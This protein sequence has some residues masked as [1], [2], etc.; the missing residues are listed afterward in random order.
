MI[1]QFLQASIEFAKEIWFQLE[2]RFHLEDTEAF[3]LVEPY[4]IQIQDNPIYLLASLATLFLVPYT[5]LKVRSLSRDRERKLDELIEEMEEEYDEDDPRKLRRPEVDD[6]TDTPPTGNE[7]QAT[8]PYTKVID[9]VEEIKDTE[10]KLEVRKVELSKSANETHTTAF[11]QEE[12]DEDDPRRLRRPEVDDRTDSPKTGGT[13]SIVSQ[14]TE[15]E[16]DKNLDELTSLDENISPS[17]DDLINGQEDIRQPQDDI[18]STEL[19]EHLSDKDPLANNSELPELNEDEQ[20]KEIK[21]LQD[22][23]ERTI[24][25]LTQQAE[26]PTTSPASIKDLSKV[27]VEEDATDDNAFHEDSFFREDV[28]LPDTKSPDTKNDETLAQE[29]SAISDAEVL[30][31]EILAT[32]EPEFEEPVELDEELE[33]ETEE[34][35]EQLII[36]KT[37][38]YESELPDSTFDAEPEISSDELGFSN[39]SLISESKSMKFEETLDSELDKERSPLANDL[40]PLDASDK[41]IDRLKFLQTRFENRFQSTGQPMANAT[42]PIEKSIPVKDYARFTAPRSYSSAALPPDSEKYMEL[43]ESFVFMKDQKKHK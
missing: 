32:L 8:S 20:D 7:E 2:Y 30:A 43:L 11:K 6:K 26:E 39:E 15:N 12:Y 14:L 18:E 41:L 22:E 3:K 27:D 4:L 10:E 29:E 40:K 9:E 25:Q 33:L 13:E 35:E 21:D 5:L 38:D 17:F 16:M 23:M 1:E 34:K 31:A 37:R 36:P 24:N 19:Y 28:P 42:A